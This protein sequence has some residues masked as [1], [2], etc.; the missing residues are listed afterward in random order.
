[1]I[2]AD[3]DEPLTPVAVIHLANAYGLAACGQ[4]GNTMTTKHCESVTCKVDLLRK[5]G[6][7]PVSN[8]ELDDTATTVYE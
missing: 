3:P 7:F 4:F 5:S 1:V 6:E 8:E 2:E